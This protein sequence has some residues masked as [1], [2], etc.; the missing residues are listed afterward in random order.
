MDAR[1]TKL[2]P[3]KPVSTLEVPVLIEHPAGH[4][5]NNPNDLQ[6]GLNFPLVDDPTDPDFV[7]LS[8]EIYIK[9]PDKFNPP[10]HILFLVDVSG[11]MSGVGIEAVKK[12]LPDIFQQLNDNDLITLKT[13]SQNITE[14]IAKKSKKEL[15]NTFDK[16]VSE[17][18]VEP[19]TALNDAIL[20]IAN[21][22]DNIESGLTTVILL[23]DGQDTA[24]TYKKSVPELIA[25]YTA[26]FAGRPPRFFP[27][28]L[29]VN[30]DHE[31]LKQCA[32]ATN[33][34]MVDARDQSKLD[35]HVGHVIKGLACG[36]HVDIQFDTNPSI[37][38][39]ILNYNTANVQDPL[40]IRK[41]D[42]KPGSMLK[43]K[44]SGREH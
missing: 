36:V 41:S 17:L 34:G 11:S 26:K 43:L 44:I 35:T 40:R 42:I 13:F 9:T 22:K 2:A 32:I 39:G 3:E 31:F 24:S 4:A 15:A 30:Y 37:N 8:P 16:K 21:D 5:A 10:R 38:L 7:F 33:F 6:I 28:G 25:D 29:G 12:T 27:I 1:D 14:I 18:V 23:S 20:S 19:Y